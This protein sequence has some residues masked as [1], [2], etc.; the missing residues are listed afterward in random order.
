MSWGNYVKFK[1]R[2][3]NRKALNFNFKMQ[4]ILSKL[5]TRKSLVF[6]GPDERDLPLHWVKNSQLG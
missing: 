3:G 4:S 5:S 1:A 2:N 6:L